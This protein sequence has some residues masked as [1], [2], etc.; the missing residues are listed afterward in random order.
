V[1]KTA[2]LVVLFND[3]FYVMDSNRRWNGATADLLLRVRPDMRQYALL[4]HLLEFKALSL[5]AVGLTSAELAAK[6]RDELR[7]LP[8]V[9][10]PLREAERQLAA[11]REVLERSAEPRSNCVPRRGLHRTGTVGVVKSTKNNKGMRDART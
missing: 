9:A 11:Y 6:S 5:N 8:V 10:E 1:V 7:I 2:F 3:A 4:D